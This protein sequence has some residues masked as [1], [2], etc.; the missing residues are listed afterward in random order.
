MRML[1]SPSQRKKRISLLGIWLFASL[2]GTVFHFTGTFTQADRLALDKKFL[3]FQ[4]PYER[5]DIAMITI[6]ASSLDRFSREFHLHWP[7]PRELYGIVLNF[8]DEA[9]VKT[10]TFDVLFDRPDIDRIDTE[11]PLSDRRFAEAV[12]TI[13]KVIIA[14]NSERAD[15]PIQTAAEDQSDFIRH[16]IPLQDGHPRIPYVAPANL[17]IQPLRF[18]SA[19]I[20]NAYVPTRHD[21]VIRSSYLLMPVPAGDDR[22][23]HY[24]SL[25]MA[26]WLVSRNVPTAVTASYDKQVLHIDKKN[27][28]LQ[29]DGTYR[30]NWYSRGGVTNGTFPYYSFF[31]VFM[32]GLA[33][34][35][36]RPENSP[37]SPDLFSGRHIVAGAS[38]AGLADIKTTP[39]SAI[40]P[41]PGM[42]IQATILANLL[43]ESFLKELS[44]PTVILSLW[45]VLIPVIFGIGSLRH[46]NSIIMAVITPFLFISAG[47]VLFALF[48]L[49]VPTV[50]FTGMAVTGIVATYMFRYLTEERQKKEIKAAF[51]QYIQKEFV[52]KIAEDPEQLKLGGQQKELTVLFSDMANFTSI[53]ETLPP[54]KLSVFLNDYLTDMTRIV[55]EHGGTLDKF[56]GDAVMA[57][58]GAPIDQPDHALRACRCAIAMQNRLDERSLEWQNL[59]YPPVSIRI[60]INTGPMIVGNMGS[61]DR[62][63]YT[64]LG[65]AVN[66]GARL[67]PLNK[68]YNTRVMISEFTHRAVLEYFRSSKITDSHWNVRELDSITVKGKSTSVTVYEL[69]D[70]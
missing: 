18:A 59:G 68:K 27:I 60:G 50:F 52:E 17:P 46:V 49:V 10:V 31:D 1:R 29:P 70:A 28:P 57:F 69:T 38:A 19:R 39:F 35:Q 37:L 4:R 41:Y 30:I 5:D 16:L 13:G 54:G 63:N 21:G 2:A 67:E 12:H 33:Y 32:S 15:S 43:D 8:L 64:V 61:R 3:M 65:D 22:N 44:T 24:P 7:W 20:G 26:A 42:E 23:L 36:N 6:D 9:D 34:M 53:S 11:G 40:E 48:R 47:L 58:W 62:F 45:I 55:F 56:I 66:L 14:G 25:P 51:G